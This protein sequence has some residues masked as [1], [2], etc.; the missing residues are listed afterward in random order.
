MTKLPLIIFAV[1]GAALAFAL[2]RAEMPLHAI[3]FIG[4]MIWL[5]LLLKGLKTH[6]KGCAAPCCWNCRSL[7]GF[8]HLKCKKYDMEVNY[9]KNECCGAWEDLE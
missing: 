4:G 6:K 5:L 2:I 7:G 1:L 8:L 3:I 9:P